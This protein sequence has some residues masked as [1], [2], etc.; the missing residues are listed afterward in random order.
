MIELS[1]LH[2]MSALKVKQGVFTQSK[3]Q[4]NKK[5]INY[6]NVNNYRFAAQ[7]SSRINTFLAFAKVF[8]K[9]VCLELEKFQRKDSNSIKL[10][11]ERLMH[12][13]ACWL[14]LK[15]NAKIE[16]DNSD[17]FFHTADALSARDEFFQ[18]FIMHENNIFSTKPIFQCIIHNIC[19]VLSE[20]KKIKFINSYLEFTKKKNKKKRKQ[21]AFQNQ[22]QDLFW[23][24]PEDKPLWSI[25]YPADIMSD[26][27]GGSSG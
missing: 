20:S 5:K 17:E 7:F 6:L 24:P 12:A 21:N 15:F 10:G 9:E 13:N 2:I 1:N 14:G 11:L 19:E 3:K 25:S 16:K 22:F 26:E 8:S 4:V 27:S 23:R 18:G